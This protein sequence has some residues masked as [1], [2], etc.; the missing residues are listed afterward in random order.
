M[1]SQN[2][3]LSGGSRHTSEMKVRAHVVW[4][5]GDGEFNLQTAMRRFQRVRRAMQERPVEAVP[6]ADEGGQA[7]ILKRACEVIWK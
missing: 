3:T 4:H 6:V 2:P 7:R 1:G 5:S